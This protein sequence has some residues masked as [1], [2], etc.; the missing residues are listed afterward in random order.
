MRLA[1]LA[2]MISIS[3]ARGATFGDVVVIGG[4]SADIALDETR[5][6]LYVANFTASRIDVLTLSD[7]TIRTSMHVAAAPS[8][9]ALSPD[10]R[11]LVVTHFGN[12]QPP[13]SSA[14][15]VTVL[16]LAGGGR[17][18]LALANTPLGVAFGGDGLALV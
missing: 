13:A 10:H 11:F 8:A 4:Q 3:A 2:A 18:V 14:N 12:L 9:L 7:H 17:Q 1:V 5:S 6:V 16:D 15:A